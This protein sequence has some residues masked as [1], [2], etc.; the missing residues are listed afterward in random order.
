[1]KLS[2]R[3]IRSN[4]VMMLYTQNRIWSRGKLSLPSQ[5]WKLLSC[6]RSTDWISLERIRAE[7]EA[8]PLMNDVSNGRRCA[9]IQGVSIVAQGVDTCRQLETACWHI[10]VSVTSNTVWYSRG[11]FET[12]LR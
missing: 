2:K 4:K 8:P 3:R 5:K 11:A 1:M 9:G 6:L 10:W 12:V 7:R